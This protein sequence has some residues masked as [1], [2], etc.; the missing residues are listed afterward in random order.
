MRSKNDYIF[1][2]I[3]QLT[4]KNIIIGYCISMM[5]INNNIFTVP[6]I[7]VTRHTSYSAV[8]KQRTNFNRFFTTVEFPH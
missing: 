2:S 6:E 1:T 8:Q 4:F 3:I 5:L 7:I